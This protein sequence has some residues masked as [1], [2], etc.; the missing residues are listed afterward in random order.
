MKVLYDMVKE[1]D[2]KDLWASLNTEMM[3][4]TN[5][6]I[7]AFLTVYQSILDTEPDRGPR[8]LEK[9]EKV[10]EDQT[11]LIVISREL[12]LFP[13]KIT[14]N[15]IN[16]EEI[17]GLYIPSML[18]EICQSTVINEL[19]R[20][21][22][23]EELQKPEYRYHRLKR[24][25]KEDLNL[26]Y[27]KLKEKCELNLRITE[28]E[29]KLY[30]TKGFID[31]IRKECREEIPD[32]GK[33]I[34]WDTLIREVKITEQLCSALLPS[35]PPTFSRLSEVISIIEAELKKICELTSIEDQMEDL[36]RRIDGTEKEW[37]RTRDKA[38]YHNKIKRYAKRT[39]VVGENY[40]PGMSIPIIYTIDEG[41][42]RAEIDSQDLL[43]P[44][45]YSIVVQ[46]GQ[47]KKNH[48]ILA[49]Y[50]LLYLAYPIRMHRVMKSFQ[51]QEIV[52]LLS[53]R[54][55]ILSVEFQDI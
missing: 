37:Q 42:N 21:L 51:L 9:V 34:Y 48:T 18:C 33:R 27:E 31:S 22:I 44:L 16:L 20:C 40:I 24:E 41:G 43:D 17:L 8:V 4:L 29:M 30:Q 10:S 13:E 49:G 7:D 55:K 45:Q 1:L 3:F 36:A 54:E 39:I 25:L 23:R 6:G 35:N 38:N 52:Y 28:K 5:E 53:Q 47:M 19:L 50:I 12:S 46:N 2:P 26:H 15:R 11:T 32:M 14:I